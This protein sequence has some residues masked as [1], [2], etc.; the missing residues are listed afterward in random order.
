MISS[1]EKLGFNVT[2]YGCMTCI[3][4]SGPLDDRVA[5]AIEKN[6][7]VCC[8][9]LS[10]NRNF[11][12]RIHPLTRANYLGNKTFMFVFSTPLTMNVFQHPPYS[13]SHTPWLAPSLLTSRLSR[14]EDPK[15]AAKSTFTTS[16]LHAKKSKASNAN[17][18]SRRCSRMS[19]RR[20]NKARRIGRVWKHQVEN[21]SLGTSLPPTSSIH[22]FSKA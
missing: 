10:G 18:S 16:G 2:G 6:S 8:G 22:H 21:C 11:E 9:V 13:S 12:G 19:T 17:S 20:L 3:G 7:L 5:A 4:N 15:T 14:L 1:L